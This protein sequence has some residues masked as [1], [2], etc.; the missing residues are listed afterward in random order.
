MPI[1]RPSPARWRATPHV[2][3]GD[4]T[5][6]GPDAATGVVLAWRTG[7][8][9]ESGA[10]ASVVALHLFARRDGRWQVVR[11]QMTPVT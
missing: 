4:L 7:E 1:R 5:G 3:L 10:P 9:A 11:R 8:Q 2:R 6:L